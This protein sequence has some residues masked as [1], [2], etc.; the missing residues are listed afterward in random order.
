MAEK[1][2]ETITRTHH[3]HTIIKLPGTNYLRYKSERFLLSWTLILNSFA[4]VLTKKK[5]VRKSNDILTKTNAKCPLNA[6]TK[7]STES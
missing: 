2:P 4:S 7:S 1:K 6:A 3:N 5:N